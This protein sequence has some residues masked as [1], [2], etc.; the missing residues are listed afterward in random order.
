MDIYSMDTS[1]NNIV[2][3]TDSSGRDE[4]PV[5]SPDGSLIAFRTS[6][7]GNDEVYVMNA[8][9]R[10]ERNLTNN[11]AQDGLPA[12]SPDGKKIAFESDRG[13]DDDIYVMNA[14]GTEPVK[15]TE[16]SGINRS[17]AWSPDG[18]SIVFT[19]SR[20]GSLELAVMDADGS[21]VRRLTT[22]NAVSFR[23]AWSPDGR[24][25]AF[26]ASIGGVFSIY[27]I[28]TDGRGQVKLVELPGAQRS[29]K[30]SASGDAIIFRSEH[31]GNNELYAVRRDGT[32]LYRM[33][34]NPATDTDGAWS[35]RLPSTTGIIRNPALA[36]ATT[37]TGDS[38][39]FLANGDGTV[40]AQLTDNTAAD[41]DPSWSPDGG[42]VAF[43]SDR[44]GGWDVY[45]ITTDGHDTK[46]AHRYR[47]PEAGPKLVAGRKAAGVL[48]VP[49]RRC[50]HLRHER[51]RQ[52]SEE[53][54]QQ[55]RD[56]TSIQR[57]RRTAR[58]SRSSLNGTG[59][60]RFTSWTSPPGGRRALQTSQ[61]TRGRRRGRRTAAGYC[62][63]R[64]ATK[65]AGTATSTYT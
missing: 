51:K 41:L 30:W 18:N 7:D 59:T 65:W 44:D 43:V 37:R 15:L 16:G 11:Q 23:S 32:G 6:R 62:S 60:E 10:G 48:G 12:W 8:D 14:D 26:E 39:V 36:F 27:L 54:Y 24:T 25:I 50:G 9:G 40:H 46:R 52:R 17:P 35:P 45:T 33:T 64:T 1:G 53:H 58:G 49:G 38:E 20:Y 28:N 2:R 47:S 56:G 31:E 22:N 3:L 4:A 55:P 61:P 34:R 21:N 29:P 5:W 13:G 63:S 57:G 19:T 42:S